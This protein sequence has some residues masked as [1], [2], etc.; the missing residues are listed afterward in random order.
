MSDRRSRPR[1]AQRPT[2]RPFPILALAV[3]VL[4]AAVACSDPVAP[5]SDPS[6]TGRVE[7][8]EQPPQDPDPGGTAV[9]W[10]R[11]EGDACGI[12]FAVDAET[13]FFDGDSRGTL[14]DVRPGMVADVWF[15]G[16]VAT[17]CP[18]QARADIVRV[19]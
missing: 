7:A 3:A 11:P 15:D 12:R 1:P 9:V 14:A 6:F 2:R 18:A 10:V 5:D 17:S 13:V 8:V 19:R 16:P 4:G